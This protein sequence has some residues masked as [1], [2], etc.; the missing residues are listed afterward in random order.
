MRGQGASCSTTAAAIKRVA[1]ADFYIL[2]MKLVSILAFATSTL[3]ASSCNP[4]KATGCPGNVALAT[5]IKEDFAESSKYFPIIKSE[6]QASYGSDGL[7][8]SIK[9]RFD[10]P[11]FK[12]S[13][14]I[15]FGKVEVVM[16]AAEGQ[17]IVSSFYLQSDDLDEIDIE[18]L[19]GDD[20]QFQSNFFSKG[21]VQTYDRGEFHTVTPNPLENFH[22]YTIDWSK[23]SL[24][25]S[26]DGQVVRTLLPNNPQ[27]YPQTPM[28][29]MGGIWAGG[30]SSNEPGTIEWA[31]GPTTY[32]PTYSMH[33]KS[34][35]VTD[36]STGDKYV[37]SNQSGSWQSI[38]AENGKVNGRQNQADADFKALQ[39]GKSVEKEETSSSSRSSSTSS[40][41]SSSSS[42]S[43]ST[44][45]SSSSS[46][47]LSSSSSSSE[48][49]STFSSEKSSSSKLSSTISSSS[50]T[51]IY[52]K[53]VVTSKSIPTVSA[54][55]S[56]HNSTSAA[57]TSTPQTSL[58]AQTSSSISN[59][60]SS[61]SNNAAIIGISPLVFLPLLLI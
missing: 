45:S 54:N 19:G 43:S 59:S 61:T 11:S 49:S 21:N 29:I 5:S 13:F 32:G 35:I 1:A 4:L 38:E 41:S 53:Y 50:S 23:G 22:T 42:S 14:Y 34:L 47:S 31:G 8:L 26:L 27:G 12:S 46:S 18:M 52:P 24:T 7:T 28:Y 15:M 55:E 9:K 30:D 20:T 17:G 56:T 60:S 25:W 51:K 16:Q 2:L 37:Y 44:S 10:N 6:A 57:H 3:A 58:A 39:S 33:I 36:Y 40:T 48:S